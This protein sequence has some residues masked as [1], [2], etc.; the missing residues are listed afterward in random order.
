MASWPAVKAEPVIWSTELTFSTLKETGTWGATFPEL[1][2][3]WKQY[4]LSLTNKTDNSTN[5][6]HRTHGHGNKRWRYWGSTDSWGSDCHRRVCSS[7]QQQVWSL[8]GARPP[9]DRQDSDNWLAGGLQQAI[10]QSVLQIA[11]LASSGWREEILKC[12]IKVISQSHCKT[13]L[14][15]RVNK[16]RR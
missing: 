13:Y 1:T 12:L 9:S 4:W 7:H 6:S 5:Q 10:H 15:P 16:I 8:K 2:A 14:S 3:V 11:F